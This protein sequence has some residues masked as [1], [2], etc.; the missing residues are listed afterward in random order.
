VY[1]NTE[2]TEKVYMAQLPGF[3]KVGKEGKVCRLHKALLYSLKQGSRCWY[4]HVCKVFTKFG[5]MH[6]PVE[7]CMFYKRTKC[8]IIIIV[9]AVDDLTLASHCSSLLLGCKSDLQSE[10]KIS[11]MG[12]IHWLLGV[13]IKRN[14]LM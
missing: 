4:L 5:Y 1:L 9:I 7:Q 2:L 12:E 11:D 8:M 14:R 10:I 6:C 3:A 13:E